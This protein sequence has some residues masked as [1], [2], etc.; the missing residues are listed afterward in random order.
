VQPDFG[1]TVNSE[2]IARHVFGGE[3]C[4]V[5]RWSALRALPECNYAETDESG[6]DEVDRDKIVQ[7][8]G[9]DQDQNSE[10]NRKQRSRIEDHQNTP[11]HR[12]ELNGAEET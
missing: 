7:E 4:C 2:N 3:W 10:K 5:S 1:F 8:S 9:E 12:I 11:I 6:K